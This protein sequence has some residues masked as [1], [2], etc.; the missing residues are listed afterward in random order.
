MRNWLLYKGMGVY[1]GPVDHCINNRIL[2]NLKYS[3]NELLLGLVINTKTT[4]PAEISAPPTT[5]EAD[6]QMA[7]VD[8]HRF[9][10]Y[11]QIVEHALHRKA[12]FDKQVLAHPS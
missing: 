6:T 1:K 5:E 8:Q 11:S 4:P 3:P 10:G 2:P 12:A 9:D 7:Y